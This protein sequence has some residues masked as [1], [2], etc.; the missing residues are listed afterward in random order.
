M[1]VLV[2]GE[3]GG[4]GKSTISVNLAAKRATE[5]HDILLVDTDKQATANSWATIRDN[6]EVEPRVTCMQ[7]Q[8]ARIHRDLSEMETRFG[9]V[10]ID[11][12]GQDSVELRSALIVAN[13]AV[14]PLQ[15]SLADV[16]TIKTL[17]NLL[18]QAEP[19]NENLRAMIV[20]NRA[21]SNPQVKEWQ[22]A[23]ELIGRDYDA[24]TIS[25]SIIRERIA[26]RHSFRSG[27]AVHEMDSKDTQAV[28][29]L[30]C[31]YKEIF[32]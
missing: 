6:L 18:A 26:F 22:E 11:A 12:G 31:L 21:S 30:S 23:R 28:A 32:G 25:E 9:D 17:D 3:K 27:R 20:I 5:G 13:I 24:F 14:F 2:G 7:K 4:T 19:F 29:E 16:M 8:G 10:I 1:I 15:P